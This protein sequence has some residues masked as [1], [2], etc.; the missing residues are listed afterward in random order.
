MALPS[1]GQISL[2]QMHV[3]AGGTTGT[4][5]SMNDSDIRGLVSAAA[6]SQMTF[7]S[8]YGASSGILNTTIT[9]GTWVLKAQVSKGFLAVFNVGSASPTA[10]PSKNNGNAQLY[11]LVGFYNGSSWSLSTSIT[12]IGTDTSNSGFNT[13]TVNGV[14]YNRSAA[15]AFSATGTE[16]YWNWSTS[17]NPVGTSTNGSTFTAVFA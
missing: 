7:S 14:T 17:S 5:A 13:L 2:N 9:V 12:N 6:N 4:Q 1:S 16:L 3:E 15:S 11:S 8:F 10:F